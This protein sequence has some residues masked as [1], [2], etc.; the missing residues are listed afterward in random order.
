VRA[1][2]FY[3]EQSTYYHVYAL[4]FFLHTRL[5]AERNNV[6]G[7][8]GLDATIRKMASVLAV[9]AQGGALPRF[10]DDDGGRLFDGARNSP[11][12]MLDPL[13]TAAVMYRNAELKRAARDLC[14]ETLWLLGPSSEGTFNSIAVPA[15]SPRSIALP[16]SGIYTSV[17]SGAMSKQ[18]FIDAGEQGVLAAGHGHA[19]ALSV[20]L[21]SGGRLWLTDPGSFCYIGPAS[22]RAKFRGT[23]AHNTVTVDGLDQADQTGPFSWG[24]LPRVQ[25]GHWIAGDAF[26]LFAG[27]HDGYNR[28][29]EAVIHRRWV[30]R[31]GSEFWLVRDVLDGRGQH[32]AAIHWRFA[33][34]VT[35]ELQ[36]QRVMARHGNEVLTLLPAS[37]G[38]WEY[39]VEIDEYSPVYGKCMQAPVARWRT[40]TACPMETATLVAFG[41]TAAGG[42]LRRL[43]SD[44]AVGYE[45]RAAGTR[46]LFCFAARPD[47]SGGNSWS[48]DG[49][50]SDALFFCFAE[51]AEG[52]RELLLASGSYV[53]YAGHRV[54]ETPTKTERIECRKTGSDWQV[55]G[56]PAQ[57]SFN[58]AA[59]P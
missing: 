55:A 48:L 22:R 57:P 46:R 51:S 58:P 47:S 52:A 7:S 12:E 18:L 6:A 32:E 31:F 33:P 42:T 23:A 14:E 26:D 44:T 19:D 35:V 50:A 45:Y 29:S 4:D 41:D 8:S 56:E 15:N 27:W 38:A 20:Q 21:A 40:R 54:M 53:D 1:D 36:G 43:D 28:L 16:A 30:V 17:S 13:A 2:G 5:L 39:A 3:F 9:L 59:L 10:G 25:V 11:T 49:W 37:G 34:E 24:P